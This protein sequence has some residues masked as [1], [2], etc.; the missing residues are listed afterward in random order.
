MS[1]GFDF[2]VIL[3]LHSLRY[4]IHHYSLIIKTSSGR[5]TGFYCGPKAF[6]SPPLL[7]GTLWRTRAKRE[8]RREMACQI[9]LEWYWLT[10]LWVKSIC[11]SPLSLRA[12]AHECSTGTTRAASVAS[13]PC[14]GGECQHQP[15]KRL[16]GRVL[17]LLQK[18]PNHP[19]TL[20]TALS[21]NGD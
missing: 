11:F 9:G 15:P 1:E 12:P 7:D 19:S 3:Q 18:L 8:T 20:N 14:H 13:R 17:A 5:E 10:T 2:M 6:F 4:W 21:T 16:H